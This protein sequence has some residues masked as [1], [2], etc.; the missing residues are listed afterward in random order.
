[1][2]SVQTL[3]A[4]C[5]SFASCAL[6][7][8]IGVAIAIGIANGIAIAVGTG[9]VPGRAD[10]ADDVQPMSLEYVGRAE[11]GGDACTKLE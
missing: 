8:S 6:G 1:M 7:V 11:P 5:A 2:A 9:S 4:P 10:V 3:P